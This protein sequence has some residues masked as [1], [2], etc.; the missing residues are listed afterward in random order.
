MILRSGRGSTL[1][2]RDLDFSQSELLPVGRQLPPYYAVLFTDFFNIHALIFRPATY[3]KSQPN[4]FDKNKV[5][6]RPH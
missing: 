6:F 2:D 5:M 1:S 4:I 3:K